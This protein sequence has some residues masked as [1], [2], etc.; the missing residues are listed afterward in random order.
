L[1]VVTESIKHGDGA[2]RRQFTIERVLAYSWVRGD[3]DLQDSWV[4]P[5]LSGEPEEAK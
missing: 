3:V 5:V 1:K 2:K 4:A